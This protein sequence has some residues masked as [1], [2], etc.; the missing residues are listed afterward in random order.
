MMKIGAIDFVQNNTMTFELTYSRV[1]VVHCQPF[2]VNVPFL[3]LLNIAENLRL[4]DVLRGYRNETLVLNGIK[5]CVFP[6]FEC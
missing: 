4:F 5:L 3:F 2:H 1:I 6:G